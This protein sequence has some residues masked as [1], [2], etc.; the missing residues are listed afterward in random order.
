MGRSQ[1]PDRVLAFGAVDIQDIKD[2]ATGEADVGLGVAG[3]PSQH[4]RPIRRGVLDPVGDQAAKRVLAG[5]TATRIPTG[6]AGLHSG[7]RQSSVAAEE[8]EV[9][10]AREGVVQGQHRDAAGGIAEG[11][12][13]HLPAGPTHSVCS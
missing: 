4:P 11:G 2:V 9:T 8:L 3:P 7:A 5:L 6:A 10:R 1:G 12:I 13:A